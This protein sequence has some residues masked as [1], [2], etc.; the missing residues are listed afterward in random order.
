[1]GLDAC[2]CKRIAVNGTAV[3]AVRQVSWMGHSDSYDRA[4]GDVIFVKFP[5]KTVHFTQFNWIPRKYSVCVVSVQN[6]IGSLLKWLDFPLLCE[7]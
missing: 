2:I 5:N 3:Q 7:L 4:A 1:M 6:N